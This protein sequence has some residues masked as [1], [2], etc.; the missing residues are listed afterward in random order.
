MRAEQSRIGNLIFQLTGRTALPRAANPDERSMG[1]ETRTNELLMFDLYLI[2]SIGPPRF[3]SMIKEH[4]KEKSSLLDTA[5]AELKTY[6]LAALSDGLF[7]TLADRVRAALES[8]DHGQL[9]HMTSQLEEFYRELFSA[10]PEGARA[11]SRRAAIDGDAAAAFLLGQAAFAHLLAARTLDRRADDRFLSTIRD[12]R[13]ERYVRALQR[14]P[15]NGNRLVEEIGEREETVSRKLGVLRQLGIVSI[16]K[17]GTS[18]VNSLTPAARAVLEHFKIAPLTARSHSPEVQ[19]RVDNL[20]E[21][22]ANHMRDLP[23]FAKPV[24]Q[25]TRRALELAA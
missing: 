8:S 20:Q 3:T 6:G 22:L 25:D 2:H 17:E 13:Y 10:M 1:W 9:D 19:K 21:R 12:G 18:V 24:G 16:R 23:S 15:M 5:L 14:E 7:A 4:V 11:A